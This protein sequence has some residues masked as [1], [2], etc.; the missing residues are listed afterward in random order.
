[1]AQRVYRPV[2]LPMGLLRAAKD[3]ALEPEELVRRAILDTP[4]LDAAARSLGVARQTFYEWRQA[5]DIEIV[6]VKS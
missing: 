3:A 2:P 1:M 4:T 5:L 6:A